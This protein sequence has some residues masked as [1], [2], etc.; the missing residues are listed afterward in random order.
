MNQQIS[1][2]PC[3][4]PYREAR[5]SFMG[6][7]MSLTSSFLSIPNSIKAIEAIKT[8]SYLENRWSRL[9]TF[10][11]LKSFLLLFPDGILISLFSLIRPAVLTVGYMMCKHLNDQRLSVALGVVFTI[12]N[13]TTVVIYYANTETM[14]I[15]A[16]RFYGAGLHN[17]VR[18]TLMNSLTLIT[19]IILVQ[20]IGIVF[21]G[22][23]ILVWLGLEEILARDCTTLLIKLLPVAILIQYTELL[24]SYSVSLGVN[25]SGYGY[26]IMA[27]L[28]MMLVGYLLLLFTSLGFWSYIITTTTIQL[29]MFSVV[30]YVFVTRIEPKYRH[31][32]DF[33]SSLKTL[34]GY[35]ADFF[36]FSLAFLESVLAGK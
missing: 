30:L 1:S 24:N 11:V 16:S 17:L 4:S 5:G 12:E 20:A 19:L 2:L 34:G 7:Q 28:I 3:V 29:I 26:M 9:P 8:H 18:N 23:R 31:L 33:G 27:S 15:R 6:N 21:Y 13:F 14:M 35:I 36:Y 25:I 22:T 10:R 32:S